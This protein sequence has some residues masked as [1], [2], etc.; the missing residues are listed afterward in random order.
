MKGVVLMS[1]KR[2][3][4]PELR[5]EIVEKYLEGNI[6][7]N[8]L[9][10]EYHVPESCIGLWKELYVEHGL[11]GLDISGKNYSGEFK[12][13]VIEYMHTTGASKRKTAAHFKIASPKSIATWERIYNEQGPDALYKERKGRPEKMGKKNSNKQKNNDKN[14]DLLEELERLRMENEYLKKLNALVQ[15]REKSAQQTK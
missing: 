10:D 8:R 11:A 15:K 9:A 1:G 12:V 14:K 2:I 3:Y 6:S 4:P 13:S 5:L 7:Y